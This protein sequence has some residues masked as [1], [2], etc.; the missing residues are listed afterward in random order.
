[1][2]KP[3]W[4]PG[5]GGSCGRGR[6]PIAS[7]AL[8]QRQHEIDQLFAGYAHGLCVDD[9]VAATKDLCGFPS[10]FNAPLFQRIRLLFADAAEDEARS[11]AEAK[12]AGASGDTGR[13]VGMRRRTRLAQLV[14]RGAFCRFMPKSSPT[15]RWSA[16]S[17]S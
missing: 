16:S 17:G 6:G 8:E 2:I 12:A 1:M 10:F 4:K 9:F 3:F 13:Q 7:D 11:H 14:T 5:Q 15:T